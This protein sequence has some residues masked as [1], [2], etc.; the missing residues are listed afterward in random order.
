MP[1]NSKSV[2][3]GTADAPTAADLVVLDAKAVQASIDLVAQATAA[4]MTKPTPCIGW[5][6]YGLLAHM[7]TEHYGFAAASRGDA[8]PAAWKPRS[9]GDDPVRAYRASAEHL[10][11]A[12]AADGVPERKF[13]LPE[14]SADQPFPARQAISFHLVDYVVHSW[15]VA[16]ALG[17]TVELDDDVVEAAFDIAMIV[18]T[19]AARLAPGAVFGPEMP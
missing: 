8:D 7:A 4:D 19:G 3:P 14:F 15:D 17:T 12:F 13:L 6:L 9:L 5:T 10:L 16:K 2:P 1:T 11:E 18:P